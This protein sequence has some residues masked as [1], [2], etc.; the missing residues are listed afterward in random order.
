MGR[1]DIFLLRSGWSEKTFDQGNVTNTEVVKIWYPTCN[2]LSGL[3][4]VTIS[5]PIHNIYYWIN[6]PDARNF[7][8]IYDI[9]EFL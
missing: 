8:G 7:V 6:Y 9:I 4:S 1:H 5:H 3:I 2:L